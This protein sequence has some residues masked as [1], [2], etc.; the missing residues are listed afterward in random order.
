MARPG[1]SLGTKA[2]GGGSVK[3]LIVSL[4][5]MGLIAFA[6]LT[7]KIALP[8]SGVIQAITL[9]VAAVG[10]TYSTATVDVLSGASSLVTNKFD[11]AALT[12]G[13]PVEKLAADLTTAG[14][15]VVAKDAVISIVTAVSGGSSPTWQGAD[16]QIDY[17]PV[18]D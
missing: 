9:N 1:Y 4:H 11:V 18:G 17:V 2:G 12:P 13:T 10:G 16:I 15:A 6:A 3:S 14:K 7:R 5:G 8:E